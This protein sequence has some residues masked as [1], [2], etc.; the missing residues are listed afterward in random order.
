M[1]AKF[2]AKYNIGKIPWKHRMRYQLKVQ[3]IWRLDQTE[4]PEA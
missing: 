1:A 2:V 3:I 4:K